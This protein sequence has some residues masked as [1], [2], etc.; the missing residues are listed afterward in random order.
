MAET[1]DK[2]VEAV[3]ED[4]LRRSLLGIKKYGLTLSSNPASLIERLQHAY[5]EALD[6]SNYLKWAIKELEDQSAPDNIGSVPLAKWFDMADAPKDRLI[7][8]YCPPRQGLQAMT[9][10]VK[11]HPVAGFTV[12]ELRSPALWSEYS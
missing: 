10:S 1:P 8:V 3:R 6:L 2:I 9:C 7:W 12:D 5:E 11:W 4:L